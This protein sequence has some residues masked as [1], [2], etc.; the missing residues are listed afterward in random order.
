MK[1]NAY[2]YDLLRFIIDYHN[3]HKNLCSIKIKAK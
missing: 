2:Q 1:W 3:N